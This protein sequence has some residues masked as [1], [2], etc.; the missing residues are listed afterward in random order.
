M[1]L[2]EAAAQ[3]DRKV[4]RPSAQHS[5]ARNLLLFLLCQRPLR[6]VHECL[7]WT[8]ARHLCAWTS[9]PAT[10]RLMSGKQEP[11]R[12]VGKGSRQACSS[13]LAAAIPRSSNSTSRRHHHYV[14]EVPPP[15]TMY[16]H[17]PKATEVLS[18]EIPLAWEAAASARNVVRL[19]SC[20]R[21]HS[22]W[23]SAAALASSYPI[24]SHS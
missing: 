23:Q 18:Y 15:A 20:R 10:A 12:Q 2:P 21:V 13:T 5:P 22:S 4:L 8:L 7:P 16:M 24:P 9:C 11:S 19:V 3:H 1:A 14:Q 17:H 6:C